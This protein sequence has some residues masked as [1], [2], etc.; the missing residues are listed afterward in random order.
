MKTKAVFRLVLTSFLFAAN[1]AWAEKWDMPLAYS[2]TNYHSENAAKFAAAITE[3]TGGKL[4]IVTHPNGS[5]YKGDEIYG[6]VKSGQVQIGERLISA[7][8][9]EQPVFEI[10]ALPFLV[11]GFEDARK[12]YEAV[13]PIMASILDDA[14]L[15]LLYSVPWPPQGLY[16]INPVNSTAD[17]EGVKFR[18]YN[19]TTS[20]LAELM[21]ALPSY[22]EEIGVSK[23]FESGMVESMITSSA[24]GYDRKLWEYT[25][26]WYDLRVWIPKNMVFVNKDAWNSLDADTQATVLEA[27]AAA[28]TA[29]W[30]NAEKLANW[31]KTQ[32]TENGMQVLPPSDQLNQEL[33]SIGKTMTEEWLIRAGELGKL[34]VEAYKSM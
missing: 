13:S 31:Y 7:L 1:L 19:A 30:A 2:A 18:S 10:D 22:I 32:L 27:A 12:L 33:I 34:A 11:T 20:R 25:S 9:K 5:L 6:A 3:A 16:T 15:V 24:T 21:G 28:E 14:G 4:E 26:Y 8:G 23:A 17:M 29:G